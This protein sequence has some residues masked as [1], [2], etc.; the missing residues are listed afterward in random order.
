MGEIFYFHKPKHLRTQIDDLLRNIILNSKE[1]FAIRQLCIVILRT[2]R[3]K[4]ESRLLPRASIHCWYCPRDRIYD[5]GTREGDFVLH[6]IYVQGNAHECNDPISGR[7][8]S[9]LCSFMFMPGQCSIV[10]LT[11]I[12]TGPFQI[13]VYKRLHHACCRNRKWQHSSSR[14]AIY[15]YLVYCASICHIY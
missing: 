10:N 6:S 1:N 4:G 7:G 3:S 11:L 15:L 9:F 13:T 14:R 8:Y 5:M 2:L 12:T